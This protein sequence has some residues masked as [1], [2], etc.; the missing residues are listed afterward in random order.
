M[1]KTDKT[2]NKC[3]ELI[4]KLTELKKALSMTQT[5]S[6]R[7]PVHALG[8]GWSQDPGT[9]A[10][11]HSAHG[12]ISTTKHPAGHY[13][14]S[15][16]GRPVGRAATPQEAGH[17]IKNYIGSLQPGDTG[18][19]NLNPMGKEE[20]IDK[21]GYG[22]KGGGQYDPA[23]NARRKTTNVGTERF[24]NQS[25]KSYT[26]N[27]AFNR[28]TPSGA[29]G[30]VKQY[31]PE[32][33]A[34]INE[35]RKLKKTVEDAPW[36]QH[37]N[38]PNADEE[39]LKL[40]KNNPAEKAEN[41]MANQLANMMQGRAM[42]GTPPPRQPTDEEMFGHLVPSEEMVKS[43]EQNWGGAINNWLVEASKPIASRF[44]SPEEEQAYWDSIKV[45]DRDDGKAGY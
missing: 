31:T 12:I 45:A 17:K 2:L 4:D 13:Q 33:I 36:V 7:K 39:V 24:G 23:A 42:L 19:H 22:P 38:V 8:V 30:P 43:A 26:H 21:S 28:K 25:V 34:A 14:I 18:M 15:H 35:A 20:E 44:S 16:G 41:L 37:S 10:F 11:H 5:Q 6:N 32:Q 27:K 9:G 1:S 3:E 29:A 40:K